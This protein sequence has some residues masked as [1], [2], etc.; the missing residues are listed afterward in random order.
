MKDYLIPIA[1]VVGAIIIS[2]TTYM[3]V[4]SHDRQR[5]KICMEYKKKARISDEQKIEQCK[6]FVVAR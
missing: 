5:F 6:E 3:A 4:T 1:I 2:A